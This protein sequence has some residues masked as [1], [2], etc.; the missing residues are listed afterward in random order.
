MKDICRD[1]KFFNC[2]FLNLW[3]IL[4]RVMLLL[5]SSLVGKSMWQSIFHI[6]VL[7]PVR[8]CYKHCCRLSFLS[9]VQDLLAQVL[10]VTLGVSH[11]GRGNLHLSQKVCYLK[12]KSI[13][14]R[15]SLLRIFFIN[16]INL[17]NKTIKFKYN[18]K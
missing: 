14:N 3:V 16:N 13:W 11:M 18:L 15:Y 1:W 5:W 6:F 10:C 17:N 8:H 2:N 12:I 7:L 4:S 9:A